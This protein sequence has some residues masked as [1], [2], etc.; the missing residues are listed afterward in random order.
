MFY[1]HVTAYLLNY[2][3]L[4]IAENKALPVSQWDSKP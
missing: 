2:D 3:F 4:S 1:E